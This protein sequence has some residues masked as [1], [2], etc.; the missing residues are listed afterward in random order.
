M[1]LLLSTILILSFQFSNGQSFEGT[2]I[3]ASDIEVAED[4]KKLGLTKEMLINKLQENDSYSDTIIIS[5]KEGNYYT[6]LNN[7]PKSWLVYKA[8]TNKI[9]AMQDENISDI[10]TVT[11]ASIDLEFTMTGKKPVIEKLDTTVIIDGE[12]C[13]IVRVQWKSGT[14][15]YYYNSKKLIVNPILFEEHIYD[16]WADFLK[17]SKSLPVKI[18][19]TT[20][21]MMEVTMTLVASKSETIDE[22]LF[23]IP[24]LI[25]DKDLNTIK[26]ANREL[27]RIK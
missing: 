27:M 13:N 18:V 22:H 21:G 8:E 12:V 17:I 11:D 16:G 20:K 25:P 24:K 9:Y 23:S 14:Y 15:D 6:L 7:N 4:M 5:Y 1:K 10:C 19:K 26:I 3:Y 2:L